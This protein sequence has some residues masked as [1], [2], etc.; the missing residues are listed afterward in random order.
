MGAETVRA[1]VRRLAPAASAGC[2]AA[3]AS[4]RV[5]R[6]QGERFTQRYQELIIDTVRRGSDGVVVAALL[7]SDQGRAY[8]LFD[9]ALSGRAVAGRPREK[10]KR[11]SIEIGGRRTASR[12]L[13]RRGA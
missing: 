3:L 8:L 4:D 9:T 13:A 10:A 2:R 5:F 6:A 12:R 7:G 1:R 11:P